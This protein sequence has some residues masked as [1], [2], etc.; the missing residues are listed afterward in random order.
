MA[1]L[2]FRY[3]VMNCGKST[4][5]LQSIHNYEDR[6]LEIMLLKPKRDTK[7]EDQVVSRIGLK[8][9]VDHLI[10]EDE[11]VFGYLTA[12]DEGI[13]CIFVDEAQF[14]KRP[15][16]D[17]LL[18]IVVKDDIPAI[19]YGLRTD[20]LGNGFEGSTRLLEI[21]HTIEEMKTICRCGQKSTFNARKVNGVFTFE[22]DQVAIDGEQN[23]TYD[24]LC[25]K[26]FFEEK[27]K[28]ERAKVYQKTPQ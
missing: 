11:D 27:R 22:G 7:G 18:H 28:F 15:Q 12:N 24:T 26:C 6:G 25:P 19:C 2:Y 17:D 16:V 23:V 5:L 10:S 8:R 21:A 20:F 4:S 9:K 1:K 3:G 14:L 13:S